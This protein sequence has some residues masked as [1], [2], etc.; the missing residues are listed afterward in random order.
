MNFEQSS[1][2]FRLNEFATSS[3]ED[4]L[5]HVDCVECKSC[6][7]KLN[8]QCEFIME[9]NER[10]IKC[11]ECD[12]FNNNNKKTPTKRLNSHRLS[13]RQKEILESKF[14]QNKYI[15]NEK[16]TENNVFVCSL[17][18]EVGCTK[19]SLVNFLVKQQEKMKENSL[20]ARVNL[21]KEQILKN[22]AIEMMLEELS[23]IDRVLAPNQCPFG[24]RSS[25]KS[26]FIKS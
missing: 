14:F 10:K 24:Q 20:P 6:S 16:L 5:A 7:K 12:S 22:Q 18:K 9:E 3:Q 21:A 17:A 19:K 4:I 23:K 15:Q 8:T 2:V 13:S 1:Q 11:K 26:V 25:H